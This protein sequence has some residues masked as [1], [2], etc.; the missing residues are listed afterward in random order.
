MKLAVV[1][2][3]REISVPLP[4]NLC[5]A[6]IVQASGLATV[7]NA[8]SLVLPSHNDRPEAWLSSY[9][10]SI[11]LNKGGSVVFASRLHRLCADTAMSLAVLC[12][13]AV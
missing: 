6:R 1:I 11:A 12:K 4:S 2:C 10:D 7:P 9:A 8:L 5:H 3:A 13:S